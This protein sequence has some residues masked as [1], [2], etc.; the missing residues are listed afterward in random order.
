MKHIE[1]EKN[2]NQQARRKRNSIATKDSQSIGWEWFS[3]WSPALAHLLFEFKIIS[4]A[5]ETLTEF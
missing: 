1:G 2:P 3:A 4:K 5:P